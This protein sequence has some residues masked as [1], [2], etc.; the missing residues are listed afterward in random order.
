MWVACAIL[1]LG[2]GYL[3]WTKGYQNVVSYA[4]LLLCPVMHLFMHRGHN[5]GGQTQ[6]NSQAAADSSTQSDRK[7]ACH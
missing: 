1:F 2:G 7:P 3:L 4:L 6:E 5:H